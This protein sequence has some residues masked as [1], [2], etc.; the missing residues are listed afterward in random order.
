MESIRTFIAIV[1][2]EPLIRQLAQV[3][4]QL[5]KKAP[6]GSVRWVNPEGIHLTL[7][8]LGD[9][10]AAKL[11]AIR[12]ALAAV[13]SRSAPCAFT[14]GGLGCFPNARRPRVIWVGVQAI[15]GE[16]AALQRAV[17]AAMKPLGFPPEGREF[18]PHLTLG[19]VRD[20][21]PP[22]DLSRLSALISS[23]EVGTLGEVTARCFALIRSDLKPTGAEYTPL[24]EFP[25]GS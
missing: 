13:A 5:E 7:K 23:T 2:P 1:L 14:V 9:T 19:R 18:T 24:A 8:F 11:D 25:L 6:P 15:G 12:A 21:V 10:P 22:T 3:Q 20:R 17:E 16:L 4:Q